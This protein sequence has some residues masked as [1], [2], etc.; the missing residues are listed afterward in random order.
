MLGVP[1]TALA[2][3][4]GPSAQAGD[5]PATLQAHLA[6]RRVGY[7]RDVIVTGRAPANDA[8]Q[9][10][11]LQQLP[12]GSATW[13]P[14][15]SSRVRR[16]GSF[17][18]KAWLRRSGALR[19]VG[20]WTAPAAASGPSPEAVPAVAKPQPGTPTARPTSAPERVYVAAKLEVP[21]QDINAL[22]NQQ[23]GVRGRLLP[24]QAGRHLA[25]QELR[26]GR[27]YTVTTTRT[28][29]RGNFNLRYVPG[30][31]TEHRL[32]VSFAG[33]R[34]N[35][36]VSTVPGTVTVYQ[37]S[38]ASQYDDA[39]ATACGIHAT[40]GVANL[41]LPCGTKVKFFYH[42]RAITAVVEDR[43]PYVGGREWDLNQNLAAA[44]GFDGVDSVWTAQ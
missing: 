16:D 22:G 17:R 26:S 6:S 39:G 31:N 25:L 18:L 29:R 15:A 21:R 30:G 11:S 42:G 19:A 13:R 2:L 1:A 20:E 23:V 10:V 3:S 40:Y 14:V 24:G 34:S 35:T 36:G 32:R 5:S 41:S 8:G 33:D 9:T 27:W 44:L 28:S 37:Q 7:H 43:G 4:S 38:V 12:V